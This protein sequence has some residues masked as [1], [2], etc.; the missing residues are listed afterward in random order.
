MFPEATTPATGGGKGLAERGGAEGV[1]SKP[2]PNHNPHKSLA[3]TSYA[4]WD[5]GLKVYL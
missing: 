1:K 4:K 2:A 3:L 5:Q